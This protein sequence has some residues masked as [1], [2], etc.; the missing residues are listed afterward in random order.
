MSFPSPPPFPPPNPPC[1][2]PL[3]GKTYVMAF[4]LRSQFPISYRARNL[5]PSIDIG[6]P[7]QSFEYPNPGPL[8]LFSY[9][10]PLPR[11]WSDLFNNLE[12]LLSGLKLSSH[13]AVCPLEIGAPLWDSTK[14][15]H[16]FLPLLVWFCISSPPHKGW[17]IG[18]PQ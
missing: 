11:N 4:V 7:P 8:P 17:R 12:D 1:P 10:S 13:M 9:V 2:S 6:L 18:D 14:N 16:S 3:S 15:K 5:F